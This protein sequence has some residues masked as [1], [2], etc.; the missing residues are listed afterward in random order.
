MSPP[1]PTGEMARSII[2]VFIF[3]M[4]LLKLDISLYNVLIFLIE[5]YVNEILAYVFF[6]DFLLLLIVFEN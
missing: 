4:A 5:I 6:L 3:F 2:G 1:H